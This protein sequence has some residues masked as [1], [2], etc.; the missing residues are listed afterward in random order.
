MDT[1]QEFDPSRYT[2]LPPYL[3]NATTV[4]L[5][6][7]RLASS[8]GV[9]GPAITRS[10]GVLQR[11]VQLLANGMADSVGLDPPGPK[12]PIDQAADHSWAAVELRLLGWLEL[13]PQDHPE[14]FHAQILHGKLFADGLRFT[15]L[16]YGAQWAEAESR[17]SWLKM[18]G[19]LPLLEQLI[20]KPFVAE[21]LSCHIA[22]GQMVGADPK[23]R[24][25]PAKRPDLGALRKRAQQA[26]LAHQIQL[27]ALCVSGDPTEHAAAQEALRPVDEYREKL[28]PTKSAKKEDPESPAPTPVVDPEPSGG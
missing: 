5:G 6:R 21:L 20:G 4:A 9:A 19:Q 14:V 28:A 15:Q 22:Y 2:R 16:E 10:C 27:V 18:S 7:Q 13:P 25:V 17:I 23:K 3:D 8:A 24:T 11:A 1:E 12:R 26:I